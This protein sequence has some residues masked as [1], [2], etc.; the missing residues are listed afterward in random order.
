MD[1]QSAVRSQPYF[2]VAGT[3]MTYLPSFSATKLSLLLL[4][5]PLASFVSMLTFNFFVGVSGSLALLPSGP[6]WTSPAFFT[7]SGVSAT[8][9][10]LA[11]LAVPAPSVIIIL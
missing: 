7:S 8:S 4:E 6:V 5:L 10:I 2:A 9:S 3:G 11:I 1:D